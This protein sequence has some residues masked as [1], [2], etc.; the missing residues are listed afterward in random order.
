MRS[1]LTTVD[2]HPVECR[3]TSDVCS[4][5]I[6]L[7]EFSLLP[8]QDIRK[9]IFANREIVRTQPNFSVYSISVHGR[10][11]PSNNSCPWKL[12]SLLMTGSAPY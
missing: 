6:T 2:Q 12:D 7:P 8:E 11:T 4:A 3:D 9:L 1:K 10:V 5:E